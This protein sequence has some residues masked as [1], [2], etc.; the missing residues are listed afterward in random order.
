MFRA[1]Q[2]E[3]SKET[4]INRAL[5]AVRGEVY[6]E[7]GVRDASCF[8]QI[9]APIKIGIDP[10]PAHPDYSLGPGERYFQM[11]SD[12]FFAEEAERALRGKRI[13]AALVDG[14]HE[15]GQA[16]RDVLNLERW[17]AP[18]GIIF[19]HDCNPKR[20]EH[21]ESFAGAW[22]GDVWKA[23]YFLKS[24][25]TDLS[26]FTLKH[27]FGVGVLSGFG[28]RKE[29]PR[30]PDAEVLKQFKNFDYSVLERK[31]REILD[32][33]SARYCRQFIQA[34]GRRLASDS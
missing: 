18:H 29:A 11:T 27:D 7:I 21:T 31:R 28:A 33:R 23:A 14:L 1:L 15:F 26:F 25:R 9:N 3:R 22:N 24:R 32:L 8:R 6:V 16:L 4:H 19:I 12:A 10:A 34:H 5:A 13:D 17:M 30:P 20:R 2:R